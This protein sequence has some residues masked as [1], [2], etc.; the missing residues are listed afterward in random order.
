MH[1]KKIQHYIILGFIFFTCFHTAQAAIKINEVMYNSEGADVD[2][3]EIYNPD[4][5]PINIPDLNLYISNSTSNHSI[6]KYS[7]EAVLSQGDYA[8]IVPTSEASDFASK[9]AEVA[10]LF[11]A[12]FSLPNKADG[13]SAT[14]SINN[15]D[16]DS[17]LTSISYDISMG[18]NGDGNSLQNIDS[19]WVA[20]TP[21]P[22]EVNKTSGTASGGGGGGTASSSSSSSSSTIQNEIP[23]I[24]IPK[25]IT[26][27][28]VF[29]KT[30]IIIKSLIT[31]NKNETLNIGRF[32]WNFGDGMV[33][34]EYNTNK[35]NHTYVYPGN[36]VVVLDYY[37]YRYSPE[38]DVTT[39][40]TIKVM[41]PQVVISS[42]GDS[43]DPYVEIQNKSK[44]EMNLSNWIIRAGVNTFVIPKNT[45]IQANNK[46]RFSKNSTGFSAP[47]VKFVILENSK[48]TSFS[49]YPEKKIVTPKKYTKTISKSKRKILT[50]SNNI[51]SKVDSSS[52][53]SPNKIID[54]NNLSASAGSSKVSTTKNIYP[55]LGLVGVI[56]LGILGILFSKK[57]TINDADELDNEIRSEDIKI[58]E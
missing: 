39:Q 56:I 41:S 25:I 58:I 20:E 28:V 51:T 10:N 6:K 32:S 5:T 7:G 38:P 27:S 13:S 45:I 40:L 1:L 50:T 36:Y 4:S 26:P 9:W 49:V 12:S 34:D 53:S 17:P 46:L 29:A 18:A 22:G 33:E 8:V 11:T 21:T 55:Y 3:V 23:R 30:P 57:K 24:I 44:Y 54:L 48:G 42:V 2:W 35:V 47:N 31:T 52:D 19:S 14:V 37:E 43:D 16:K 15:G